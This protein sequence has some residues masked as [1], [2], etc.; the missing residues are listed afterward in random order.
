MTNLIDEANKGRAK[1]AEQN[2]TPDQKGR[3]FSQ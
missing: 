1:I 2:N 3:C